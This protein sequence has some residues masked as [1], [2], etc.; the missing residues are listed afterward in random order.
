MRHSH[1]STFAA[2]AAVAALGACATPGATGVDNARLPEAVRAP[3]D[4]RYLATTTGVGEITYECREKAGAAGQHEWVFVAPVAKLMTAD[5]RQVGTYTAGPTWQHSDGSKIMG[6][7]LAVAPA[8]P[9]SIPLQLVKA[10]S[11]SGAGMMSGVTHIQR[12]NTQGGVAPQVACA[13]A[14]KGARQQVAYR[15]DYVFYGR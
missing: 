1:L 11:P 6:K 15:A 14:N 8:S 13:D 9:G 7:Q 2:L 10:E 3:A 4:A 5:G 12:L